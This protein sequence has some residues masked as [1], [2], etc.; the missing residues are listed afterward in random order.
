MKQWYVKELS[1]LTKVT[2]QTLHHYDHIGLLKPSVRL[3][4][5]YRLYSEKDLL[6]L[7]QIIALKFFGFELSQIK[8]LLDE[9]VDMIDHFTVQSVFLE[10]KA[11]ALIAAN[12]A[13]KNI[14]SECHQNK[15]I[16]WESIIQTIEAYRMTQ[17]LEK[18]WAEK[19]LSADELKQWASFQ[20]EL[21]SRS[22]E[23]ES[24]EKNWRDLV[25]KINA[26]LKNDPSSEI[27]ISLAKQ[28]MEM[29]NSLYGDKYKQLQH[30]VW[31]K[32]FKGGN[33]GG[34]HGLSNEA[35]AWLDKAVYEYHSKRIGDILVQIGKKPD[36]AVR[37]QWNALLDDMCGKDIAIRSEFIDNVINHPHCTAD[38]KAWLEKTK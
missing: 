2:V 32:G 19:V 38:M 1:Q 12:Q 18:T 23:K 5:N 25:S 9:D 6:K 22:H 15:S 33:I 20:R 10:E 28:C 16:A 3:D 21:A 26:N 36:D 31:E 29:V 7:Q 4:N 13:L 17:Q 37:K 11:N 14:L 27:A 34:E 30:V 35:V 24:F 8:K